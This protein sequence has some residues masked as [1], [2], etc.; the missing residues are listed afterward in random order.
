MT[1]SCDPPHLAGYFFITPQN[2]PAAGFVVYLYI[3]I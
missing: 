2:P 1:D 3:R